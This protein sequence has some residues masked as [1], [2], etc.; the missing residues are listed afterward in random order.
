MADYFAERLAFHYT[1]KPLQI[2]S[3]SSISVCAITGDQLTEEDLNQSKYCTD[4]KT[5][6][7]KDALE[8][9]TGRCHTCNRTQNLI[10]Y[11]QYLLKQ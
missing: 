7:S 9:N 4:C 6:V 10:I 11:K 3:Q 8:Y 2:T 1:I 5:I